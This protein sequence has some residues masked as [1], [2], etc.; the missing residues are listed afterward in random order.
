MSEWAYVAA[1]FTLVW[2]ALVIYAL[3]LARRVT[4]A[5]RVDE[6][7]Q[8]ALQGEDTATCDIQPAP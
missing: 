1:S 6:R 8:E 2:A 7:L 3:A 5:H 4:Q